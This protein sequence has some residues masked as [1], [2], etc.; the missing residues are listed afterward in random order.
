V[1]TKKI[2]E[3]VQG[4]RFVLEYLGIPKMRMDQTK[5]LAELTRFGLLCHA[6]WLLDGVE[7]Y[8][9][10]PKKIGKTGRHL[11]SVQ[12]CLSFAGLYTLEELMDHNR[13][14]TPSELGLFFFMFKWIGDILKN[15]FT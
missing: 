7:K 1:T 13:P 4:Y 6:H 11:A 10:D 15:G 2:L 8:A 5:T 12:M 14:D 3:V 9:Q